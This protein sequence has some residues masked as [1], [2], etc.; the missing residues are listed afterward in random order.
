MK[1]IG[2]NERSKNKELTEG[3]L[4][5]RHKALDELMTDN[6]ETKSD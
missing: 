4:G 2:S 6:L 5:K 1:Y 3:E